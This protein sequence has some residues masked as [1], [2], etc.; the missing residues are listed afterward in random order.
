VAQVSL[1]GIV[2]YADNEP[3]NDFLR[4]LHAYGIAG[5]LLYIWLLSVFLREGLR[6]RGSGVFFVSRVGGILACCLV[7][8][9]ILSLTTE[10]MRY[11]TGIW[12]LFA[13]ASAVMF[14]PPKMNTSAAG[15]EI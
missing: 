12:Y 11:P 14:Q 9:V 13:L 4:F 7:G 8:V 2:V 5:L 3:H 1:P 6:F 15:R 10:P